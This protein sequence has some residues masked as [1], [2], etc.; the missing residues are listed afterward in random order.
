VRL[1]E[2]VR[3]SPSDYNADSSALESISVRLAEV[4]SVLINV[5]T[6]HVGTAVHFAHNPTSRYTSQLEGL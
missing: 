6:G 5:L 1:S 4:G 2:S 3:P